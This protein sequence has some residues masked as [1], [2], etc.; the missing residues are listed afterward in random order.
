VQ[1]LAS[2]LRH[3]EAEQQEKTTTT[4]RPKKKKGSSSSSATF[5]TEA[6]VAARLKLLENENV[7]QVSSRGRILHP[8]VVYS[9]A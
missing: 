8:R 5:Y 9:S 6:G 1:E 3:T 7:K 4:K 2:R